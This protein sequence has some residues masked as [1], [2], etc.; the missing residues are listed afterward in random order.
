MAYILDL[1]NERI[2]P[3]PGKISLER[4]ILESSYVTKYLSRVVKSNALVIY[5][6][7]FILS[8]FENGSGEITI[9]WGK[10]GGYIVS[11]QGNI[12]ED[13]STIKRRIPD[14]IKHKCIT[15]SEQRGGANKIYVYLPSEIEGCKKLIEKEESPEQAPTNIDFTDYYTEPSKRRIIFERDHG[16]CVYCLIELSD[17]TFVLDH[18]MPLS[19]GGTNKQF[20]LVTSCVDC[21]QRKSNQEPIEFLLENYRNKLIDQEEYLKQKDYV[22]RL[23]ET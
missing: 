22:E 20:N 10:V 7:L 12:I 2:N 9:P 13:G 3:Q 5:H 11:E 21:N 16:K 14:L 8:W 23:L 15:V 17:N 4:Y 1:A 6:V 19:R 18:L